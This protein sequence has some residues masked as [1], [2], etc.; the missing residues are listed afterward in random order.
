M[1]VTRQTGTSGVWVGRS[2][3]ACAFG[4]LLDE[5]GFEDG[6]FIWLAFGDWL[7]K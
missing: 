2:W 4:R 3:L 5:A 7:T 1:T 6:A